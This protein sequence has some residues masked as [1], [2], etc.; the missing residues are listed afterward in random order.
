MYKDNLVAALQKAHQTGKC[1]GRIIVVEDS[2][3]IK[4][5]DGCTKLSCELCSFSHKLFNSEPSAEKPHSTYDCK[6]LNARM[7]MAALESGN[8]SPLFK[9]LVE[10]LGLSCKF[11]K[12]TWGRHVKKIKTACESAANEVLLTSREKVCDLIPEDDESGLT[13]VKIGLDGTW[14]KRGF[15]FGCS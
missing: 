13:P 1:K 14:A 11:S 5:F 3:N 10:I 6:N 2:D 9:L 15:R 7:V 12:S 8:S 4:G